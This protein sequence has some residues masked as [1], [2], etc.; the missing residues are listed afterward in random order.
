M[1]HAMHMTPPMKTT[2]ARPD[3]APPASLARAVTAGMIAS[4]AW[5]SKASPYEIV[6]FRAGRLKDHLS[7]RAA[8][9]PIAYA[10]DRLGGTG[11]VW[12]SKLTTVEFAG[13]ALRLATLD[14]KDPTQ[15][16]YG[17]AEVFIDHVTARAKGTEERSTEAV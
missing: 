11:V 3:L 1:A 2:L 14:E 10:V 6:Y 16:L 13:L 7:T 9:L 12:L 8:S 4:D 15:G 5:L 17:L